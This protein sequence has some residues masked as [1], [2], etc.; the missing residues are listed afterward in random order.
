MAW[1]YFSASQG[2]MHFIEDAGVR[3]RPQVEPR[4]L[5]KPQGA[6]GFSAQVR[7]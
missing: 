1:Q 2:A 6:S 3:A 5:P 4:L 7:Q